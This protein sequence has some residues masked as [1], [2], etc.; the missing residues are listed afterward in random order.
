[1]KR[2]IV[3]TALSLAV[4]LSSV[5]AFAATDAVTGRPLPPATSSHDPIPAAPGPTK[6][7]DVGLIQQAGVGGNVSYARGGVLEL[8]GGLTYSQSSDQTMLS[9]APS[10]GWFFTDNLEISGI[11][12][13]S[14]TRSHGNSSTNYTAL[15]EPS[16]HLPVTDVAFAFL[17]WG[18]GTSYAGTGSPGFAM[19]PRLGFNVLVGRSGI[20]TPSLS[21]NW[22]SNRQVQTPQGNMLAVNTMYGA[23]IGYT[24]MW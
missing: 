10:I 18:V 8:G 13:V 21:F 5:S 16:V 19:A 2:S 11:V 14:H 24:V 1:M 22:S 23:N 3:Q 6:A 9:V 20:L 12:Q 7:R 4:T 17:G 15:V